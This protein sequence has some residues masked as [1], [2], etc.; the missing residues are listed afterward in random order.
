MQIHELN[1]F[2]GTPGATNF[3]AID[4]GSD[5]SRISGEALLDPVNSRIDNLTANVL[6]DSVETIL[7][8][9]D[10][11]SASKTLTKNV[12]GFDY[13]DLYFKENTSGTDRIVFAQ[14]Y[15]RTAFPAQVTI[16]VISWG[17]GTDPKY[18]FFQDLMIAISGT[19]LTMS[20][21]RIYTW[22]GKAA[23]GANIE[24]GILV[25]RIRVDGVKIS[26]N[27]SAELTDLRTAHNG[28]VY[29]SA[30]AAREADYNALDSEI[31]S[32]N[33]E[34]I[35]IRTGANERAF[36]TAG[37]AVRG[38]IT[39]LNIDVDDI[40]GEIGMTTINVTPSN[41]YTGKK[42]YLD[43]DGKWYCW[44]GAGSTTNVYT[45]E[46][47]KK[48]VLDR[49]AGPITYGFSNTL[50]NTV[51]AN[52]GTSNAPVVIEA[53]GEYLYL[54]SQDINPTYPEGTT[55]LETKACDLQSNLTYIKN[56]LETDEEIQ[57][58]QTYVG[59]R[60]YLY[61]DGKWYCWGG[62]NTTSKVFAVEEGKKY[63]LSRANG[64]VM[65]GF[66]NTLGN[67]VLADGGES[68]TPVVIEPTGEYK[69]LYSQ[70][71]N[72][73]NPEGVTT[74]TEKVKTTVSV[75]EI[76]EN[77]FVSSY[78]TL[79]GW[80]PHAVAFSKL[81]AD[82]TDTEGFMFFTDSHFMAKT[83]DAWKEYAYAIFAYMEQL[84]YASPCS[85]V[86]HGGDWLGS[87]E[88][89]EDYLY[90]LTSIGGVFR[91]R[92]DRFALLVGNHEC[93]NQSAEHQMFTHDTLANT[94]MP[95][96]GK[97]YY[98]FKANTFDMYCFDSW[99]SGALDSYA[100]EQIAW[101]ANS[102][103]EETNEHIVIAIHILYDSGNLRPFGEQL[104]LCAQAYNNRSTYTY[105]G[106]SYNFAN[107]T[108]KV[109]FIIAGHEHGDSSGTLNDIPY[110]MTRNTTGYSET[111]FAN[112][113]LPL[114]LMKVDWSNG[115]L[116][117][118]RAERGAAG[119]TR[120]LNLVI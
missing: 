45:L 52:A 95:S 74:L 80:E 13:L 35:D 26:S 105:N 14:R 82:V 78:N 69:Y 48:Y 61:T 39:A 16:P 98:K 24:P 107:A 9:A 18:L 116:T 70:D 22:D 62:N 2:N 81:M 29:A 76:Q 108:G 77:S 58:Y 83:G 90:K 66:S 10:V 102:L 27:T 8:W 120:T 60:V 109:G 5:T 34:V 36:P 119:T 112:L 56:L 4:D 59:K 110:I 11:E 104:S 84:Y 79:D 50:G 100:N 51:L 33:D 71:V 49:A 73:A 111:T 65:Y 42:V 96:I 15:P 38:Q 47:G 87:G 88:P 101:F 1:N 75:S 20:Q 31:A 40:E 86:L 67:T 7:D 30:R 103:L 89:R 55:T 72:A 97:T 21:L 41:V 106:V 113:P 17:G 28:T 3:L 118:Y 64:P 46:A 92:F 85:F 91:S 53:T 115:V 117:A 44:G 63:I 57:P 99:Q 68:N 37:D 43:T 23:D 12:S 32:V 93:G 19:T 6:P 54:Y 114:D 25:D 94:L